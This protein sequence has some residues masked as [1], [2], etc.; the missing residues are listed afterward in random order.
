MSITTFYDTKLPP[1]LRSLKEEIEG[2]AREKKALGLVREAFLSEFLLHERIY[3]L[4]QTILRG[5]PLS[6]SSDAGA[7]TAIHATLQ[8]HRAA[9]KETGSFR[10]SFL[11]ADTLTP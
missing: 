8:Q 4:G 10:L 2:Y 11:H 7:Y 6:S 5:E 1:H 9:I 3:K